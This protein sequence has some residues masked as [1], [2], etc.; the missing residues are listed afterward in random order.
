MGRQSKPGGDLEELLGS[1]FPNLSPPCASHTAGPGQEGLTE[2]IA[3]R[4][5]FNTLYKAL[6]RKS[7][8]YFFF[9]CSFLR[10]TERLHSV[11]ADTAFYDYRFFNFVFYIQD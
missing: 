8:H 7:L 10:L 4:R 5:V 11:L 3:G 1:C 9:S 6:H 2:A